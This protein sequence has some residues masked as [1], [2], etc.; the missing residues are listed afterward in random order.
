MKKVGSSLKKVGAIFLGLVLLFLLFK[1]F[2]GTREGFYYG[3]Q[4]GASCTNAGAT[5]QI[6]DPDGNVK[7]NFCVSQQGRKAIWQPPA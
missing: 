4:V 6:T 2:S 5:C 7:T 1:M 3:C